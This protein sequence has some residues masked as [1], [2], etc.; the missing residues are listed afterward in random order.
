VLIVSVPFRATQELA[1]IDPTR[2]SHGLSDWDKDSGGRRFRWSGAHA[3]VYVSGRA[4]RVEIPLSGTL[5]SKG[6]Q[7]VEVRLDG[8]PVNEIIVGADW[9]QVGVV[10]PPSSMAKSRRID[11][12]ISPTWVRDDGAVADDRTVVGVKVGE[13]NVIF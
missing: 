7:H 11:L 4:R 8:R 5:P 2:V 6:S 3:T 13:L 10:L 12:S 9:Q 1:T